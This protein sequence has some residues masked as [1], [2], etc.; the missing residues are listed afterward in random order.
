MKAY[1]GSGVYI[2]AF[3]TSALDGGEWSAS[4]TGHFTPMEKPPG[5][6]WIGGWV[7]PSA[8]LDIAVVKRKISSPRR[9]SNLPPTPSA[10][11]LS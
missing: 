4:R 2:H 7:G 8:G 9:D 5:T 6:H 3:S 1:C 10:I 11:P